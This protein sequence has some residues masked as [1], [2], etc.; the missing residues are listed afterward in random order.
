MDH[1]QKVAKQVKLSLFVSLIGSNICIILIWLVADKVLH[2]QSYITIAVLVIVA[3]IVSGIISVRLSRYVMQ[4]LRSVW[5]AILHLDPNLTGAKAPDPES[6]TLGRELAANMLNNIYQLISSADKLN[7][8]TSNKL[9]DLNNSFLAQSLPLPLIVLDTEQN[10][11]FINKTAAD[12]LGFNVFD[13]VGKNIYMIMDMAF[14]SEDTFDI[15]LKKAKSSNVTASKAWER[16]KLAIRD[17]HPELLFDMAAYYNRDNIDGNETL[18]VLFDHTKQYSQDEQAISF[19]ALGVH[20]LRAPLTLLRGYIE[21]FEDE[22]KGKLSPELESF[23]EKMHAQAEQLMAFVNNILNV[24]RIDNDQL[25]LKLE[26]TDWAQVLNSCIESLDIRARVRGISLS[27]AVADN[28]PT[29]GVDR[30]SIQE[31]INNLVDNAIKYSG[32]S[33]QIN[34][35]SHLNNDGQIETNIEDFGVGISQSV[36]PNL[37]TKFYRDHN[38]RSQIGGTGLGL[39]L[40]KAIVQA[41]G[42]NL[43]VRS[44]QGKGSVFGFSVQTYSNIASKNQASDQEVIAQ[45]HGWIKNHSLY[46][47]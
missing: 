8:E 23:M 20:E 40:S 22:L 19:V 12:Y 34:I 46:R 33:T 5:Q 28:L 47:R 13:L 29:V 18:I 30:L 16:V 26:E 17:N 9:K 43:W 25:E 4:P 31:V 39:Y 36:L 6:L 38:N 44:K 10:I 32:K 21:V 27:C 14:P 7:V 11:T 45:A 24:A 2:L 3:L 35:E 42:G 1:L 41:H 37:F 15:W